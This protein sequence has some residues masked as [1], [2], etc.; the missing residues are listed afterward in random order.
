MHDDSYQLLQTAK[1][2]LTVSVALMVFG[3]FWVIVH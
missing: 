2:L 3:L 1:F